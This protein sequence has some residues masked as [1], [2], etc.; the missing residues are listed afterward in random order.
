MNQEAPSPHI[1]RHIGARHGLAVG[2]VLAVAPRA[3]TSSAEPKAE[4]RTALKSSSECD[5]TQTAIDRLI[6]SVR[7]RHSPAVIDSA[8]DAAF[9]D[10][11]DR[12][13]RPAERET[14]LAEQRLWL[15]GRA[16]SCSLCP[17]LDPE[18]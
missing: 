15:E 3:P 6:C 2:I 12:A 16:T 13:A 4:S 5:G 10:Y 14:R 11:R 7:T 17:R 1:L 8:L 18:G 9:R